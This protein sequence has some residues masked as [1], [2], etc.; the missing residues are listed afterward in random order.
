MFNGASGPLNGGGSACGAIVAVGLAVKVI[1]ADPVAGAARVRVRTAGFDVV[2][3]TRNALGDCS[4]ETVGV[5]FSCGRENVKI[6]DGVLRDGVLGAL[7]V[8]PFGDDTVVGVGTS[9]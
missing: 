8:S 9:S 4:V 3:V 5:G 7:L 6:A 2:F 1:G